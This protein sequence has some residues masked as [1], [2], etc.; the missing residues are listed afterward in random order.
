MEILE[1][2]LNHKISFSTQSESYLL[3]EGQ[4]LKAAGG[5]YDGGD[6]ISLTNN[7]I[8][9]LFRNI[10]YELSGREIE[11]IFNP[12]Q[13]TTMLGLLKYPDDYAK[14][15][16]FNILWFKDTNTAADTDNNLGFNARQD[17]II[18]QPNPKGYF[19]FY[20][21][22]NH[23]FGF[24]VDYTK[25]IYGMTQTLTLT[26]GNDNDA[27]FKAVGVDAGRVR[28]DTITWFMPYVM[29]ADKNKMELY[30]IIERKALVPVGYRMIQ[31]DSIEVP[32]AI[33]LTWRLGI[34]S[35]PEVPRFIIVG[36]QTNKYNNQETNPA[37][38]DNINL[39]NMHVKLNALRYPEVDYKVLFTRNQLSRLYNDT[40][41]FRK[42][43][44]N[45]DKLVSNPY[46]NPPDFRRL[47]L[48]VVFDVTKQSEKLK[49]SITDIQIKADFEANVPANTMAY[50]VIISDRLMNFQ[51][52]GN[53]FSVVI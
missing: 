11:T 19:S 51:S 4:L 16:G 6:K 49:Y 47:Y 12:G 33:T 48:L 50:A 53:K 32:Q 8:M 38:F 46:I 29:P 23:I 20:I 37:L 13:A 26:R 27:I 42:L 2:I 28:L 7:G 31:C 17:Y 34:Q 41:T 5:V 14:T 22:L 35:S 36:F 15:L 44:F 21:P 18:K 25:V 1:L 39:R 40:A 52:Y 30:K 10:R 24:C 45:I 43:F 9:Y 3:L